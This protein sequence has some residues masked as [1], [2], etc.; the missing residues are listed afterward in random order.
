MYIFFNSGNV[1]SYFRGWRKY[2]CAVKKLFCQKFDDGCASIIWRR[3]RIADT[4]YTVDPSSWI[5]NPRIYS[6]T[7]TCLQGSPRIVK[8]S[9]PFLHGINWW[10]LS[11][12][13]FNTVGCLLWN[14]PEYAFEQIVDWTVKW[15]TCELMRCHP[16]HVA[17][18]L[19]SSDK[20][21]LLQKYQP[22]PNEMNLRSV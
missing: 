14:N 4:N 22:N 20:S 8:H 15:D 13:V 5:H 21:I 9:L 2:F 19:F 3:S 11:K 7:K 18:L 17:A 10:I 1:V 16:M 6:P 12:N